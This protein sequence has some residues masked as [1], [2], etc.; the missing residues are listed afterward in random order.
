[1]NRFSSYHQSPSGLQVLLA[2]ALGVGLGLAGTEGLKHYQH[3]NDKPKSALV[4]AN[5]P[6]AKKSNN[7][8]DA[9]NLWPRLESR[10]NVLLLGVDSNGHDTERFSGC[11]SDTIIIA[12]LDPETKKVALVSI[13]RDSR[14]RIPDKHGVEK[15][16]AAHALG[17]PELTV[18]TVSEDFGVPIDHYMVI[19]TA[20]LKKLFE[21]LGPVEI[22][23]EK[24][25]HY[26]D[27]AGRLNIALEP[28]VNKLDA[29]RL[30]EYVRF[31]HD[32]RGD[33][34]RIER[35]QWFL[36]AVKK[37]L[38]DP[39]VLLKL[40]DLCKLASDYVRTDLEPT[41]ML[42]LATFCK[43]LK[44]SQIQ[45]AMLPGEPVT[46]NGGSYWVPTPDTS[47]LV[48]HRLVGAPLS[49]SVIA[50]NT[51]ASIH[52]VHNSDL[53]EESSIT[54]VSYSNDLVNTEC[55]QAS[56]K[57]LSIVIKYPRG[58]EDIA[59]NLEGR[60]IAQGYN[61]KWRQRA[62]L[63]E[64][65]HELVIQSSFR[66]DDDLTGKLKTAVS[67][68]DSYPVNVCPESRSSS[69]FIIVVS[70]TTVIAAPPPVEADNDVSAPGDKPKTQ[71][72]TN[73]GSPNGA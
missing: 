23:V 14:V 16:N 52:A 37:K 69:D 5:Q 15:I 1:M 46:I 72:T 3:K 65:A 30:E 35:Q 50:T 8:L 24:P 17:G 38:E 70:P 7:P 39:T 57:P 51:G 11:R 10:M 4:V 34:G 18:K 25:M 27:R 59:K 9:I 49:V 32:P 42:K 13:P 47:A 19:D 2:L 6:Q 29:T 31:R 41:D 64:C 62:E 68:L 71:K 66:A 54:E 26:K 36:R 33:I 61:V 63:S 48:L 53:T 43:D 20:G 21:T 12:S 45:T 60:L 73:V 55:A 22:L 40:P 44:T 28:G 56:S 67:E 58:H